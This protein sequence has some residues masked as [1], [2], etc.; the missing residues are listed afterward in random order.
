MSKGDNLTNL[1]KA[2]GG[3]YSELVTGDPRNIVVGRLQIVVQAAEVAP[4]VSDYLAN[5]EAVVAARSIGG[6]C[7]CHLS[8]VQLGLLRE[9]VAE[10]SRS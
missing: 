9:A 10:S 6:R 4:I 2:L 5:L 7:G 3:A 1:K 8:Q